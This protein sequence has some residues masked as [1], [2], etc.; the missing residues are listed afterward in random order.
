MRLRPV[1]T[2]EG[3]SVK[4]S[5][6]GWQMRERFPELT[7]LPPELVLDGEERNKSRLRGASTCC[8]SHR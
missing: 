5:R 8:E 4:R 6:R 7:E 3:F 1:S 2:V